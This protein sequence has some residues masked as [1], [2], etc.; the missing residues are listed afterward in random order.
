MTTEEIKRALALHRQQEAVF[1]LFKAL[2]SRGAGRQ[3]EARMGQRVAVVRAWLRLL[4]EEEQFVVTKH[5]VDGL[6]WPLVAVEYEAR[7]GVQ[8]ARHERTLKR[9][10]QRALVKIQ[11]AIEGNGLGSSVDALFAE[12]T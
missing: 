3:S 5:L 8:Q 1:A 6:P 4:T 11:T 2:R 12:D 10:Q 9:L 7:W